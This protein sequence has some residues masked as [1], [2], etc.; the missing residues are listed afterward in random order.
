MGASLDALIPEL[1]PAARALVDVANR[2]GVNPRITSTL[3]SRTEQSRLYRRFLAGVSRYPAAP[4]GTSA[5]EYGWAFDLIVNG[6]ENQYDL[7]SVWQSWGGVWGGSSD[8]I[9]F[10]YPGFKG[11][12]GAVATASPGGPAPATGESWAVRIAQA[13]DFVLGFVPGIGQIELVAL[14]LS[15]GF[16]QSEILKYYGSPVEY[17]VRHQD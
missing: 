4:P 8:P 17:V 1:Q 6:E 13:V 11:T 3:R 7:G 15:L 9:H 5:H 10:E 2:A 12:V 14:L 16:P